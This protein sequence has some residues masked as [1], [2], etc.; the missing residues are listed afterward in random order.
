M[1]SHDWPR[2]IY[3]YGNMSALLKKK[4]FFREEMESGVLGSPP[5]EELLHCIKPSYWFSAHLH[6]KFAALIEHRVG[7]NYFT[8]NPLNPNISFGF[9]PYTPIYPLYTLG[10]FAGIPKK[11]HYFKTNGP[12]LIK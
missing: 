10:V 7:D 12:I 2:G 6:C 11:H 8:L 5:A 1:M 9:G 3:D 4:S